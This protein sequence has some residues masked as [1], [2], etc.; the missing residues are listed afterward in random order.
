[1]IKHKIGRFEGYKEKEVETS[2]Y[3]DL[4]NEPDGPKKAFV[5]SEIFNRKF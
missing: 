4:L 5:L 3:A 2:I 1:M